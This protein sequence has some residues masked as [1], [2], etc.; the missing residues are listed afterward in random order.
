MIVLEVLLIIIKILPNFPDENEY[1]LPEVL[2]E[3]LTFEATIQIQHV[4]H[5]LTVYYNISLQPF[6]NDI[7]PESKMAEYRD[8]PLVRVLFT[9][10][11]NS[12]ACMI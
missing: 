8:K 4:V 6:G 1:A 11:M 5:N 2:I 12:I 7:P 10:R 9:I 3:T